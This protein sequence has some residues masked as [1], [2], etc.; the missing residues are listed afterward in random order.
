MNKFP[1]EIN[2]HWLEDLNSYKFHF[3][4]FDFKQM[5]LFVKNMISICYLIDT[6]V[7]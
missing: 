2:A 3:N 6:A 5:T 4:L 7:D 1:I